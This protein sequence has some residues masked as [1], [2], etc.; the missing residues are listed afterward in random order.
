MVKLKPGITIHMKHTSTGWVAAWTMQGED[1]PHLVP[2][3]SP[4]VT[5]ALRRVAEDIDGEVE[6]GR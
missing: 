6:S 5:D 4:R 3:V 2:T 1:I